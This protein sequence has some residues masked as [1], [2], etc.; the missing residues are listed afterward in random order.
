MMTMIVRDI[1]GASEDMI[2]AVQGYTL[3]EKVHA[4]NSLLR[5]V[6]CVYDVAMTYQGRL[7]IVQGP[8]LMYKPMKADEANKYAL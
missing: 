2:Y 6:W 7:T 1:Q 8:K 3:E 4:I 5:S